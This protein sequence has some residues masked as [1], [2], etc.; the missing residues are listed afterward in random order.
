M[1]NETELNQILANSPVKPGEKFRHYK[2]KSIYVVRDLAF[3]E[4][5][6]ELSVNYVRE[7]SDLIWN[8]TVKNFT[9]KIEDE[10]GK[11]FTRFKKL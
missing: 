11:I 6:L 1:K 5:N 9:E 3:R 7:N 2:T 8:R 4:E 10:Y